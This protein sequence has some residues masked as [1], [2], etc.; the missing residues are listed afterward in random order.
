MKENKP[1]GASKNG[2]SPVLFGLM[3]FGILIVAVFLMHLLMLNDTKETPAPANLDPIALLGKGLF[4]QQG[5]CNACH[6]AEGRKA[7]I[8]PR[9][10]TLILGDDTIRVI[11]RNG[12]GA[13][14]SNIVLSEDDITKIIVYLK[15]IKTAAAGT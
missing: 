6:S 15:A 7:G 5:N 4:L 9:L 12:R 1:R 2:F 11:I 14:P 13:M 10:S 3:L 8:G